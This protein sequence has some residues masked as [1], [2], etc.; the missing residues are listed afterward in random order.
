M[1]EEERKQRKEKEIISFQ[2]KRVGGSPNLRKGELCVQNA[3]GGS[4][5]AGTQQNHQATE[6]S[7]SVLWWLLLHLCSWFQLWGGAESPAVDSITQLMK[8]AL[9]VP[10][11][12]TDVFQKK[13]SSAAV[14]IC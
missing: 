10:D 9:N 4:I 13:R 6:I 8:S 2:L 14:L 3:V 12:G 5:T 7:S 11:P 1:C